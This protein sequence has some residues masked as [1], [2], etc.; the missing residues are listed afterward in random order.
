MDVLSLHML[1]SMESCLFMVN[2]FYSLVGQL[3]MFTDK[4]QVQERRGSAF[5]LMVA[6]F[7]QFWCRLRHTKRDISVYLVDTL[8]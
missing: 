6:L 5:S 2:A 1:Y 7:G 8:L 3:L 4:D